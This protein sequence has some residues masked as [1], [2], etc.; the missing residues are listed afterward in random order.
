M[1]SQVS[2]Q[3][4]AQLEPTP[5]NDRHEKNTSKLSERNVAFGSVILAAAILSSSYTLTKIALREVP[6]MTIGF[7]RF[8]I[9]A[10]ILAVWVHLIRRYPSPRRSDQLRLGLGGIIGIT[11]YFSIENIGIN[12]ATPTDAALLVAS[13]PAMTTLLDLIVYR[14]WPHLNSLIGIALAVAGVYLIVGYIPGA[15]P[16]HSVGDLLLILS[17]IVWAFYNFITR[18][19]TKRYPTPVILYY[20]IR[21]GVI[22]F[23]PL[24]LTE[25]KSWSIPRHL[26]TTLGSLVAL[27]ILCSIA[28][29]GLYA[30]GL[31]GLTPTTATNLLNLVPVFGIAISIFGLGE[32]V[33]TMQIIGG[34]IV[35]LGVTISTH[36]GFLQQQR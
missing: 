22:G 28:G 20:Q 4:S 13:Y 25:Y 18:N 12:L 6:P 1:I 10:I 36:Q 11:I 14:H 9:A 8:S 30:K 5:T 16:L 7:I 24:A 35:I 33:S 21:A 32:Q 23:F 3:T 27:A 19:L 34:L 17:G 29:L 26:G 15:S 31:Q 2:S